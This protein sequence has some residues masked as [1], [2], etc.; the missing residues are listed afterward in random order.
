MS[1]CTCNA[2]CLPS[3]P[4]AAAQRRRRQFL[5]VSTSRERGKNSEKKP[6]EANTRNSPDSPRAPTSMFSCRGSRC[7]AAGTSITIC[8]DAPR[9]RSY[10]RNFAAGG[11]HPPGLAIHRRPLSPAFAFSHCRSRR[12]A[13]ATSITIC[14]DVPL[15]GVKIQTFCRRRPTS[16]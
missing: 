2:P 15:A 3:G 5:Y 8:I 13:A 10:F 11:Q 9:T 6:L 7:A 14:I 12:A 4:A 1:R 16:S